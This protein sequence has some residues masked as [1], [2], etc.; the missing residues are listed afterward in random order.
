VPKLRTKSGALNTHLLVVRPAVSFGG[1]AF[2]WM[3]FELDKCLF[4]NYLFTLTIINTVS[5]AFWRFL[6]NGYSH[7]P[8]FSVEPSF[9]VLPLPLVGSSLLWVHC[10]L[11]RLGTDH[12]QKTHCCS[13]TDIVYCQACLT[14]HCLQMGALLLRI[15]CYG[16]STIRSLLLKH[17]PRQRSVYVSLPRNC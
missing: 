7:A 10:S 3:G 15:R 13:A 4:D 11:Y 9:L 17:S 14:I 6:F 2:H 8:L 1:L 16:N 5:N 12:P